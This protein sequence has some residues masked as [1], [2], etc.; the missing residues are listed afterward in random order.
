[1]R[2]ANLAAEFEA[3]FA[4]DHD[5]EQEERGPLA[6]G[7]GQDGVAGW[8]EFDSEAGAL[9]MM[10]YQA[11]NVRIIFDYG[12]CGFTVVIVAALERRTSFCNS[13]VTNRKEN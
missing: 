11:G 10:A 12:V 9:K 7:F 2:L 1:L 6:L 8:V 3:V 4:G 5:V 13:L